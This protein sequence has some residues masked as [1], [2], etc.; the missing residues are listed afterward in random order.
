MVEIRFFVRS[1]MRTPALCLTSILTLALGMGGTVAMF[2]LVDG[3]LLQ[4]LPY[5]D[6]DRLVMVWTNNNR[7]GLSR[8]PLSHP[9]FSDIREQTHR[10]ESLS[11]VI[12]FQWN[13][14]LGGEP[15]PRPAA[16]QFVSGT[17]FPMLGLKASL[18]RTLLPA[19]DT[20][21]APFV[22]LL[23]RRLW[24]GR[25]A[26]DPG[27]VGKSI[28]VDGRSV[29]VVGVAP[30]GFRLFEEADL[31]APLARNP[32]TSRNRRFH[33]WL[34][35]VGRLAP[36]VTLGQAQIELDGI[37]ER[38]SE[39]FPGTNE[40]MGATVLPMRNEIVGEARPPLWMLL[41]AVVC[42]LLIA[43]ANVSSLM[44]ARALARDAESS[45]RRSLGATRWRIVLSILAE[46]QILS[47]AGGLAGLLS[48]SWI[49]RLVRSFS[50]VQI[51]RLNEVAIGWTTLGFAVAVTFGA[52]LLCSA[53]AALRSWRSDFRR[54]LMGARQTGGF[55]ERRL[56]RWIVTGQI[57]LALTLLV[58]GGLL[59]RSLDALSRADLGFR[60]GNLVAME[61]QLPQRKFD[62]DSK[63]LDFG[64]R[65]LESLEA[66]PG[67][68]GAAVSRDLPLRGRQTTTL[69][70]EGRP[71]LPEERPVLDFRG[72][73]ADYFKV[74]GTP[75]LRGGPFSE[76]PLGRGLQVIVNRSASRL[77]WEG[78]DALG[79]GLRL[80]GLAEDAP[81]RR[82]IGI[83]EDIHHG[84]A[85]LPPYP[86]VYFP[87]EADPPGAPWVVARTRI[88]PERVTAAMRQAVRSLDPD[89]VIDETAPME[90][91]I[92]ES[93]SP[94][95][96]NTAVLTAFAMLATVLAVVGVYGVSSQSVR[97]R[98]REIAIRSML[99][100]TPP[101]ILKGV[102]L[103]EL[104]WT[105]L[106]LLIGGTLAVAASHWLDSMLFQ[107][108]RL[109]PWTY[110]AAGASLLAAALLALSLPA[111]RAARSDPLRAFRRG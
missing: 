95:R 90:R 61:L 36:G 32:N 55:A 20:A 37:A 89:V 70:I 67:V 111:S 77:L 81:F 68:A 106:G 50:S 43:C 104:R 57:A 98:R 59:I 58:P 8:Y 13:A 96:F 21:D 1:L 24:A 102:L 92:S 16:L 39:A 94:R 19:D 66:V 52:A 110:A 14:I 41:G 29:E 101:A 86:E 69:E 17:L 65:L 30:P 72:I 73:S 38:L 4:P 109:D 93:L 46:G 60:P 100:G 34:R 84:G 53:P 26:S 23:S 76:D 74:M 18:G 107:T 83:V 62:S 71:A 44:T 97:R 11:A 63:R 45:I 79:R 12:S 40:G 35:A 103:R 85:H 33:H 49:L 48:A 22:V 54:H 25:F 42:T 6:S 56:Q 91:L 64:R 80:S 87:L 78:E 3:I 99:G 47:L 10:L 28:V 108:A 75:F 27:I 88:D 82:V 5:A 9:D 2:A 15:E 105:G 31:W 7:E 51:P